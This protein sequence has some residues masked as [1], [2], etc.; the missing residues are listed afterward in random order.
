MAANLTPQYLK[1]QEAY[2]R[3]TTKDE[4]LKWLEVM[5]KELPNKFPSSAY[6]LDAYYYQALSLYYIGSTNDLQQALE[7]QG[8]LA[9]AVQREVSLVVGALRR[10]VEAGDVVG[11]RRDDVD[12]LR[13]HGLLAELRDQRGDDVRTPAR[14]YDDGR[15]VPVNRTDGCALR[16]NGRWIELI[17]D[18]LHTA[19]RRDSRAA[20]GDFP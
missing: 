12:V 7:A 18:L 5:F 9:L 19:T 11:L 4:E 13:R 17:H 3:A 15:A 1:A 14:R 8:A 2:R 6:A 20:H 16:H 10:R